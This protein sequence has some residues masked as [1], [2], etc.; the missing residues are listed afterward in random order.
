MK[1]LSIR[2][3][4][5][6]STLRDGF[7]ARNLARS[8]HHHMN[9]F[10]RDEDGTLIIFALML[11]VLMI[12]MGGFAVDLMRH[13]TKRTTLQQT[14][15]RGVLAAASLQQELDPES[16]VRDY[17]DK[18][19]MTEYLSSVTVVEGLNFRN[20]T[21]EAR[22]DTEPFF[23]HMMGVDQFDA[24]AGSTA[25]Q[26]ITNVEIAMVLDI[27]GSMLSNSRITNLKSAAT[28]FVETVLEGDIEKRISIAMVPFNGQVNLGPNLFGKYTTS[29]PHSFPN[30]Y[31]IDVPTSTYSTTAMSRSTAMPQS[32]HFDA[33]SNQSTQA[34][35]FTG[36]K[37]TNNWCQPVLANAIRMLNNN[38]TQLQ[39]QI[40]ALDAVGATS[41]DLG[42]RWGVTLLDPGSRSIVTEMVGSGQVPSE[43]AG[44]P[45]DYTDP[46]AL[47]VIVL[48]TDGEHWPEERLN[49][50]YRVATSNIYRSNGDGRLSIRH[51]TGRPTAAGTNEYWWP[52]TGEWKSTAYNSGSGT[53]RLTWNKVWEYAR[54]QWVAWNL[55]GNPL[56]TTTST[57]NSI[58]ASN[59]SNFRS[60]TATTTMN[61]RLQQVCTAAKA[62]NVIVFGIAFEA[63]TNGQTQIRNCAS[64]DAHYFNASG[65]EITTAFR[66]IASQISYLRLTQ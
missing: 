17:F 6:G 53:T 31:C 42:M 27:S 66:A 29:F 51:P 45:L 23:M 2:L 61:S 12:M 24:A 15:D 44:R 1:K 65:L 16:V 9:R 26:R 58:Y 50:A 59:L 21:A 8:A 47:K 35:T 22:T 55:Y 38:I 14:L 10:A 63:P 43:F 49:D 54:V 32:G 40:N 20:V 34:P 28:E 46:E 7:R 60:Q 62:Q 41:I 4:A 18:A 33:Y 30:S 48:M 5:T 19:G 64:S 57:K 25:E 13:E 56:G 36:G 39:S 3:Q 52:H 11:F 37:Y